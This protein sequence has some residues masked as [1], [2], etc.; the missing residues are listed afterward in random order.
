MKIK[1][2]M[3]FS[4]KNPRETESWNSWNPREKFLIL[5][6]CD[7]Y[8]EDGRF[9]IQSLVLDY[10]QN[11]LK[12]DSWRIWSTAVCNDDYELL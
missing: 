8:L 1:K 9:H 11:G 7:E 10:R 12:I 6:L 3:L 4:H 5:V 2:G